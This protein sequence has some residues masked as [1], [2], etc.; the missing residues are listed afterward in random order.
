M[1][2]IHEL[3]KQKEKQYQDYLVN[4]RV[5]EQNLETATKELL[6]SVEELKYSLAEYDKPVGQHISEVVKGIH[7]DSLNSIDDLRDIIK[8]L[9]A[10]TNELEADIREALS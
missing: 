10:V 4:K 5:Y 8:Q 6:K 7:K 3:Y 2:D 1:S 9:E